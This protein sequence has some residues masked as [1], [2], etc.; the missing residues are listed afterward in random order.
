MYNIYNHI[1]RF[2][3]IGIP[4]VIIH[5]IFGFSLKSTIHFGVSPI[6]GHRKKQCNT[7]GPYTFRSTGLTSGLDFSMW[8]SFTA[9]WFSR[10][11][12][13]FQCGPAPNC[14][15]ARGVAKPQV[16]MVSGGHHGSPWVTLIRKTKC[17]LLW[18]CLWVKNHRFGIGCHKNQMQ[19][20]LVS[21]AKISPPKT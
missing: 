20:K 8:W 10:P 3:K 2:P 15:N 18:I 19:P 6:L 11:P 9:G 12:A 4:P 17:L 21:P 14:R 5:L 16:E 1:W 13:G 7:W